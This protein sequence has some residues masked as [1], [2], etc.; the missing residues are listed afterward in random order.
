VIASYVTPD[1]EER[2]FDIA[3]L[4]DFES[5]VAEA[6]TSVLLEHENGSS[7][8]FTGDAA[9]ALLVWTDPLRYVYSWRG[10]RQHALDCLRA[11]LETGWPTSAHVRFTN[12]GTGPDT[13]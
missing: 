4:G 11:Y 13:R 3:C 8:A 5:L 1:G 12:D 2:A 9:E 10:P 6:C 7:L